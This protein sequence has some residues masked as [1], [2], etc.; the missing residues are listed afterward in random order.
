MKYI[1]NYR[2]IENQKNTMYCVGMALSQLYE[3]ALM[4]KLNTK[5]IPDMSARFVYYNAKILDGMQ[6]TSGTSLTAGLDSL[7]K[8]GICEEKYHP[9]TNSE[10]DLLSNMTKPCKEAYTN[11]K[12]HLTKSYIKV[13]RTVED[14]KNAIVK[15]GGVICNGMWYSSYSSASNNLNF[16]SPPKYRDKALGM[17]AYCLIGFDDEYERI[18]KGIKYKGFFVL[19][20]SYGEN[21]GVQYVPYEFLNYA[22]GDKAHVDR[23][24]QNVYAIQLDNVKNEKFHIQNQ[25]VEVIPSEDK[26]DIV[27]TLNS[28][29]AIVNGKNYTLTQKPR[30]VNGST[31]LPM[32][33]IFSLL[34]FSV[35]YNGKE[36][37]ITA[38]NKMGRKVEITL[39]YRIAYVNGTAYD[40]GV[41]PFVE[42]GVTY[43]PVRAVSTMC[44]CK[45]SYNNKTKQIHI[46][47]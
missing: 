11:A 2:D 19:L 45:V 7:K 34:G 26:I 5:N 31:Y 38:K 15:Y 16:I 25:P 37:I 12:N 21:E 42:N 39:G 24:C 36:K 43:L 41:L 29:E 30:L 32:R 22:S 33:E 6:N 1:S 4:A 3:I 20:N 17:H 47:K 10:G 8:Y 23:T 35:S 14:I 40:M 28:Q 27:L 9:F 44:D 13:N 46:T 18:L